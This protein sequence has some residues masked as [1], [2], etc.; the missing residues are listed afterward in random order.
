MEPEAVVVAV[1]VELVITVTAVAK[2]VA[3]PEVV[4]ETQFPL[5]DSFPILVILPD[6]DANCYAKPDE[7]LQ[8]PSFPLPVTLTVTPH[9]KPD[10]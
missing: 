2:A 4:A 5:P 7:Q 10:K 6:C 3:V 9:F 1:A 8:R